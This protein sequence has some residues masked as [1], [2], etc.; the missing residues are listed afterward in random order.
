MALWKP[1]WHV[2]GHWHVHVPVAEG[3][4]LNKKLASSTMC[5][6][7]YTEENPLNNANEHSDDLIP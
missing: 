5:H 6:I 3:N 4:N 1:N 2:Y 7:V